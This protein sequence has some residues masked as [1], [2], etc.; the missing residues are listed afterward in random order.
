MNYRND[1]DFDERLEERERLKK[2]GSYEEHGRFRAGGAIMI[3]L[4]FLVGG[5]FMPVKAGLLVK[6]FM[7]V[8]GVALLFFGLFLRSNYKDLVE[9]ERITESRRLDEELRQGRITSEEKAYM[10]KKWELRTQMGRDERG[11][12]YS[13]ISIAGGAILTLLG[14]I[15][16]VFSRDWSDLLYAFTGMAAL[17]ISVWL[18]MKAHASRTAYEKFCNDNKRKDPPGGDVGKN[19]FD[20]REKDR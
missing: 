4:V 18:K 19:D 9:K 15:M 16:Y 12:R 2:Q 1:N 20:D 13:V 6:G 8:A 7:L 17:A 3:G 14:F 11:A 5:L 10:L